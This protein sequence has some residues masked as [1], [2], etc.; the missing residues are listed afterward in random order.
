MKESFLFFQ[1]G[2]RFNSDSIKQ[3]NKIGLA[4]SSATMPEI[5]MLRNE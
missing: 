2:E 5:T 3:T 4:L 1:I